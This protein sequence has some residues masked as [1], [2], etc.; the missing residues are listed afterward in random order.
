MDEE[1]SAKDKVLAWLGVVL[2]TGLF[3]AF[4][5]AVLFLPPGWY[6]EYLI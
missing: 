6:L 5:Y 2:V 4:A 3:G 1:M